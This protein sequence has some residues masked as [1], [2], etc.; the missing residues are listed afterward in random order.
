MNITI[1]CV[2]EL[3]WTLKDT[4]GTLLDELEE[5][6]EFFVGGHDLLAKIE[7]A[8]MGL[9]RGDTLDLHLEP[10]EAFGDY[11]ERLVFL[12]SRSLFPAGIEEGQCLEGS[13]LPQNGMSNAP[14]GHLYTITDIYPEHVVLDGNHPLSGMALRLHLKVHKVRPATESE[15]KAESM[16]VG[17][18]YSP[19]LTSGSTPSPHSLPLAHTHEGLG[20]STLEGAG[21]SANDDPATLDLAQINPALASLDAIFGPDEDW[22]E[23]GDEDDERAT[24]DSGTHSNEP[25][26]QAF[27]PIDKR[28][29]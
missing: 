12:E 27:K 3:T 15:L 23:E 29:H 21:V 20:Q 22:G 10:E 17:F 18:F 14:L 1:P 6:V 13:A 24:P 2:V 7:E 8:L 16:G 19:A 4:L 9:T 28:L 11:D 25:P 26:G 5:G